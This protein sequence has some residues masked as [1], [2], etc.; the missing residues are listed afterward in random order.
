MRM[1]IKVG[2]LGDAGPIRVH[3]V[4][5]ALK[6]VEMLAR[7]TDVTLGQL[8][9]L[10]GMHKSTTYRLLHTLIGLGWVAQDDDQG[11]YRIGLRA[12]EVGGMAMRSWP[13]HRAAEPVLEALAQT[14]GEAVNLAVEDDLHMVYVAT[15]DAGRLLRMQLNVGRRA[16]IHCTA[17][18][19]AMLAASADLRSQLRARAEELDALTPHTITAWP[20]LEAELDAIRQQSYAIDDEEQEVGARCVA[21]PIEDSRGRVAGA[22]GISAPSARLSWER[23][24]EAGPVIVEAAH[25]IARHLG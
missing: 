19:K 23:A 20:K 15:V 12:V 24:H 11:S 5:R 16:P 22:V 18:G 2:K 4:E 9:H 25:S 13:L 6:L 14:L 10:A 17:V 8:A 7:H 1:D 3:S 21:A